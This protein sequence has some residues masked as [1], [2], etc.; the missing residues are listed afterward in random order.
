M[1]STLAD[2]LANLDIYITKSELR[3]NI[4]C[5]LRFDYVGEIQIFTNKILHFMVTSTRQPVTCII[6]IMVK[7]GRRLAYQESATER[8]QQPAPYFICIRNISNISNLR[9]RNVCRKFFGPVGGFV[10][11]ISK[12]IPSPAKNGLNKVLSFFH[13]ILLSPF[14]NNTSDDDYEC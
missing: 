11:M 2:S 1:D 6:T 9:P 5:L 10:D 7:F 4:P 14:T 13:I 12:H 3:Q 8:F